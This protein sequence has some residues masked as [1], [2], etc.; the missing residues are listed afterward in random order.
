[1][2]QPMWIDVLNIFFLMVFTCHAAAIHDNTMIMIT[3]I[4][5]IFDAAFFHTVYDA[6]PKGGSTVLTWWGLF[7]YLVI[8]C[9]RVIRVSERTACNAYS[10]TTSS[11][12][13]LTACAEMTFQGILVYRWIFQ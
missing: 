7:I 2:P 13:L 10:V 5:I 9:I 1:M 11:V 12:M 3:L 8:W 4:G 6:K